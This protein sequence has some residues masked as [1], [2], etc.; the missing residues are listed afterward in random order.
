MEMSPSR[1]AASHAASHELPSIL[2]NPKV[3]YYLRYEV[4]TAVTMK[5]AILWDV[6]LYGY[7]E[8]RHLGGS[9]LQFLLTANVV[10]SSLILFT[11]KMEVIHSSEMS[12]LT[13]ATWCHPTRRHSSFRTMIIRAFR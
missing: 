2:W 9:V 4:F 8:K 3:Q 11:L 7:C 13:R 12:V 10:P 6:M 5:N 1:Q